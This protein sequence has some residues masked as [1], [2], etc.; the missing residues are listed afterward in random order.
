MK[1]KDLIESLQRMNPESYVA[2]SV[3]PEC[4]LGSLNDIVG[5]SQDISQ[6][7]ETEGCVA[8]LVGNFD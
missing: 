2:A 7:A 3:A 6:D 4:L 1:V 8:V 5:V